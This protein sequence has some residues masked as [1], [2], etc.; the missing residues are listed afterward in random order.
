MSAFC[1]AQGC[2]LASM[3]DH[4]HPFGH[5]PGLLPAEIGVSPQEQEEAEIQDRE[6]AAEGVLDEGEVRVRSED[7]LAFESVGKRSPTSTAMTPMT[8]SNSTSENA[9]CRGFT[10][11]AAFKAPI[12]TA[13]VSPP[14]GARGS[15][16]GRDAPRGEEVEPFI[17]P[18]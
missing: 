9:R 13:P 10:C 8:T 12:K 1:F 15:D 14:C 16:G 4:R 7:F 17:L 5:R 11:N 18:A 3:L 6:R 2:A